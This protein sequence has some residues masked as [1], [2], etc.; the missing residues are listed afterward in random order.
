MREGEK[1]EAENEIKRLQVE[2]QRESKLEQGGRDRDRDRQREGRERQRQTEE[3]E[4]ETETDRG[5]GERD[6]GRQRKG[7]E[8]MQ[9]NCIDYGMKRG[10]NRSKAR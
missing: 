2:G 10:G 7:R 1:K 5:M 6:R 4:R 9:D 8:K 3:G